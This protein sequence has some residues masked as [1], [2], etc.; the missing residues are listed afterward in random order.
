MTA[1]VGEGISKPRLALGTG[2]KTRVTQSHHP[3]LISPFPEEEKRDE[4]ND[5]MPEFLSPLT[6]ASG[7]GDGQRVVMLAI[8]IRL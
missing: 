8:T 3:A 2:V 7:D 6:S 1:H 5:S 4:L